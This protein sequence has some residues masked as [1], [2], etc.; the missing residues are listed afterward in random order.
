M[1]AN[2]RLAG[3]LIPP[4]VLH[5]VGP[6]FFILAPVIVQALVTY[7]GISP[8]DA[9]T[10]AFIEGSA[11]AVATIGLALAVSRV[12]WHHLL[13]L[14]LGLL[15]VGNIA[16]ALADSYTVLVVA[17]TMTG[18]ATGIIVPTAYATVAL[19][20]K[21]DRNFGILMASLL[22][23][24]AVGFAGASSLAHWGGV[25]ALYGAM[26]VLALLAW[27]MIS[28]MPTGAQARATEANFAAAVPLL[29]RPWHV[30]AV[31]AVFANFTAYLCFWANTGLVGT[32]AGLDDATVGTAL[33]MS[34]VF[35]IAGALVASV[36]GARLGRVLPLTLGIGGLVAAVLMTV[37]MTASNPTALLQGATGFMVAACLFI[38]SQNLT[39]PYLLGALASFDRSGR[40]VAIGASAQMLGVAA[41]PAV[42]AFLLGGGGELLRVQLAGAVLFAL[43]LTLLLP[44]LLRD[45]RAA[46]PAHVAPS[47]S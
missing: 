46:P 33:A 22:T 15:V 19:T 14:A 8:A 20:A 36:L 39:H 42:A 3:G 32:A 25:S 45:R 37:G 6:Q 1:S 4:V 16:S 5:I 2:S 40:L 23:Y 9:N 27:P 7:R 31:V 34:Q 11:K 38:F 12:N 18:I 44:A 26:A 24:G 13:R 17:R 43:S 35:G 30:A 41:G 21:P 10:L 47:N 29:Q 28:R